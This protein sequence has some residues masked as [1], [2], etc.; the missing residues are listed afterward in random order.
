MPSGS[1]GLGK[2]LRENKATHTFPNPLKPKM[3]KEMVDS[4]SSICRIPALNLVR[5]PRLKHQGKVS[6][7]TLASSVLAPVKS[8]G[9]PLSNSY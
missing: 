8:T 4:L 9:R 1:S 5:T 3:Y 6:C 7:S 2:K